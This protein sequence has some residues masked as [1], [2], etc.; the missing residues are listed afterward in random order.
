MRLCH[1]SLL[2]ALILTLVAAGSASAFLPSETGAEASRIAVSMPMLEDNR[3]TPTIDSEATIY[4][5]QAATAGL[6]GQWEVRWNRLTGTP[7]RMVGSGVDLSPGGFASAAEVDATSRAFVAGRTALAGVQAADLKVLAIENGAGLWSALYEQTHRG[8]PV[9]GAR[10]D[11]VYTESGRLILFGSDA[12][13]PI[14][15]DVSPALNPQAALAAGSAGL[16]AEFKVTVQPELRI[17]PIPTAFP[18]E[19]E[20][21]VVHHLAYR[22]TLETAE[23]RGL[24]ITWVDAHSGQV[25]WRYDDIHY[26]DITGQVTE[27]VE[28]FG[29]CDGVTH[30][31]NKDLTVNV[32]GVPSVFT[33]A[34]G[35]YVATVPDNSL[36]S[37]TAMLRGRRVRVQN[38]LG[39]N[40]S[41]AG[42]T[43]PGVPLNIEWTDANSQADERDVYLHTTRTYD[44]IRALDPTINLMILDTQLLANVSINEFCNA[45]WNGSSI[46]FYREGG[47]CGNTG[48][49]GDVIYHEY[50]HGV[51]QVTYSPQSPPGDI[52]EG[53]SDIIATHLTE[54]SI[55]GNGFNLN[56]CGSGIRDCDNTLRYPEDVV[57]QEGHSAG[58]VICGFDWD[59]RRN[60]EVL[61]PPIFASHSDSLWHY[62]RKL[63][64]PLNQPAQVN[65]YFMIDDNDGNIANGSPHYT[66]LCEA[67][68]R[69]GF[70]PPG[71]AGTQPITV[72]H[73]SLHS[74]TNTASDYEVT[75]VITSTGG[76]I[77][78][79]QTQLHYRLNGGPEFDVPMTATGNPNEYRG[80]IPASPVGTRVTYTITTRD[81]AGNN[82]GHPL[83]RCD[84]GN[85]SGSEVFHVATTLD[86]EV[87]PGWTVGAAGDNA[88]TG[89]WVRVD[90]N[91]TAAQPEN[92]RTPPPGTFCF[93]TGQGTPGGQVG[94]NDVDGGTTTL[95]TPVLDL[96]GYA[97]AEILYHRWYSNDAGATPGTDFW[98]VDVSN[99]GG[100]T[101]VNVENTNVTEARW[102]EVRVNINTVF[103]GAPNMVKFRFIASDLGA[104]SIVEAGIDELMVFAST[105]VAVD[106]PG[107]ASVMP[108]RFALG[109]IV[110]N[111]F[112]P[113]T[114]ISFDL[115]EAAALSLFVY[116]VNGRLV[117]T[118]ADHVSYE[119]GSYEVNWDGRDDRGAAL[120]SGVYHVRMAGPRFF[121]TRKVVMVK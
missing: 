116:D 15:V 7:H 24:W 72:T 85:P 104:G 34:A 84:P 33:D 121:E 89:V 37:V 27:D 25:L 58:R 61:N 26:L 63:F 66:A 9:E 3:L 17:L 115:P 86:E 18:N 51:T 118:L 83:N 113:S 76:P 35:N 110:P 95:L 80:F 112:N 97:T 2:A 73:T 32:S 21:R 62:T 43:T 12:H 36:R 44:F 107:P 16:P 82:G 41:F 78:V 5:A 28:D 64:K 23:P 108:T 81:Q 100:A 42:S 14:K 60:L 74:T 54:S 6:S 91:G 57:G 50:G 111:P 40:A 101:W 90:P 56:V 71:P 10:V 29:Y 67:A 1:L 46:N 20:L 120:S 75:A 39:A 114:T 30:Q 102:K 47:G 59:A 77:D 8:I 45:F 68:D 55:I 79:T 53:N 48:R 119:A 98:V 31:P 65:G 109:P 11:L 96:S 13:R 117:R 92:D 4:D 19:E 52:H 94:E 22:M 69:H 93:V 87:T 106:E 70:T 49:M 103:G 99:D 38:N 105:T 88:A